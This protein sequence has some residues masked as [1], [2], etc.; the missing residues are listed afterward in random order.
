MESEAW[1]FVLPLTDV[2]G[3]MI[4]GLKVLMGM[5]CGADMGCKGW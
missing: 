3:G 2:G 5:F 4:Q 1:L